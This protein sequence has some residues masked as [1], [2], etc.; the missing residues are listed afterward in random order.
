MTKYSDVQDFMQSKS[1]A[2]VGVSRSATKFANLIAKELLKRKY[3]IFPVNPNMQTC[4]GQSCYPS[5]RHLPQPAEGAVIVIKPEKTLSVIQDAHAMGITK[6][7][8]QRGADSP[9]AIQFCQQNG[10]Q[11]IYGEC[12][13]MFLEPRGWIHQIHYW[14][15]KFL[16]KLPQ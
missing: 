3:R 12:I 8:L 16:G 2:V 5:L 1:L 13:F 9:E 6:I 15:W 7:W 11:V 14:I 4:F 10:M